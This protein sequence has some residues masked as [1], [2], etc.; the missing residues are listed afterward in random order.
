MRTNLCCALFLVCLISSVNAAVDSKV[1]EKTTRIER[2]VLTELQVSEQDYQ[3][4]KDT[5]EILREKFFDREDNRIYNRSPASADD[6]YPQDDFRS[7]IRNC[8]YDCPSAE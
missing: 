2:L 7:I 6:Y 4:F 5:I 8:N 1:G 3:T